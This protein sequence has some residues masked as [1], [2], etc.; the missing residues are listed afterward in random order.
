MV[1]WYSHYLENRV[2]KATVR[3]VSVRRLLKKGVPQGGILSPLIWN[4]NIDRLLDLFDIFD[5]DYEMVRYP[6]GEIGV[7]DRRERRLSALKDIGQMEDDCVHRNQEGFRM[8]NGYKLDEEVYVGGFADDVGSVVAGV[9]EHYVFFSTQWVLNRISEWVR[10]A[11]LEIS[12]TKSVAVI[13]SKS[14]KVRN[15]FED[16]EDGMKL[17]IDGVEIEWHTHARYLGVLVDQ[18]LNFRPHIESKLKAARGMLMRLKGSMGKLWGPNP[19]LTRWAYLCVVRPAFVFGHLVWGH[20][21]NTKTLKLKLAKLQAEALRLCGHFRRST[22]RMGLEMVLNVPPLDL[23]LEFEVG[24]SY[25]RLKDTLQ[26]SSYPPDNIGHHAAAKAIFEAA[27]LDEVEPD[28]CEVRS[29]KKGFRIKMESMQ[30]GTLYEDKGRVQV[31]TDGS[32]LSNGNTGLGV[33]SDSQGVKIAYGKHLGKHASVYQAEASAI[34]QACDL[35]TLEM[36]SAEAP[37]AVTIYSDSQ[38]V[39]KALNGRWIKSKVIRDCQRAL[40]E[41]GRHISVHLCWVKGHSGVHGNEQADALAGAAAAAVEEVTPL[42]RSSAYYRKEFKDFLYGRWI[43]RWQNT[44]IVFARQTK[45][46]FQ[47]PSF[48]KSRKI[49]SLERPEFSMVVRW[50]T[51]HAFLGLQNFRC[52]SVALSFCRLCGQVPERADH[53]LLRCPCLNL[54]RMDCLRSWGLSP[55][56]DWEVDWILKFLRDPRVEHLEDPTNTPEEIS[57]RAESEAEM[58]TDDSS[59]DSY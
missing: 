38:A 24:R 59:A 22:P 21:V 56:P 35:I 18:K 43:E 15:L 58:D 51:G 55:R 32:K 27:N 9:D 16:E 30:R 52:G 54:L 12:P 13:F 8:V 45:L 33:Y 41:L 50:L 53:L 34:R 17:T 29:L 49:L 44:D 46:W 47:E 5:E 39:L 7:D 23:F 31:F 48:R 6:D 20:K 2:V 57:G 10:A 42:P 19:Y 25:F 40:N 37:T 1:E 28:F 11:G 4:C 26:G 14:Q 3:G 36:D